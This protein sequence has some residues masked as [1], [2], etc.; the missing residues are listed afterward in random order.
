[1][2]TVYRKL[3]KKQRERYIQLKDRSIDITERLYETDNKYN[4][5]LSAD[6][7]RGELAM[8]I[9]AIVFFG[10]P[11]DDN[12]AV[13]FSKKDGDDSPTSYWV[14]P[15]DVVATN[16]LGLLK[17]HFRIHPDKAV[18]EIPDIYIKAIKKC[19]YEKTVTDK[20]ETTGPIYR[21]PQCSGGFDT[22][23]TVTVG[24]SNKTPDDVLIGTWRII[25]EVYPDGTIITTDG[26]RLAPA[27]SA[28]AD[29]FKNEGTFD[30][31][32]LVYYVLAVN[33]NRPSQ[34]GFSPA[35]QN[36]LYGYHPYNNVLNQS[37]PYYDTIQRVQQHVSPY[38][39]KAK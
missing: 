14:L 23:L 32:N 22:Y 2:T 8:P 19:P 1:M 20:A 29:T 31:Q 28:Y 3:T 17:N 21:H 9:E 12:K 6:P 11:D 16:L 25:R 18:L 33:S 38:N 30:H 7:Y 10:L 37:N 26:D 39:S 27:V 24:Y 34:K 5:V 15:H 4:W 13:I 35:R 36:A